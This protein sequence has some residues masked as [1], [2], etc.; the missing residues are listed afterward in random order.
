MDL[1]GLAGLPDQRD[2]D[3]TADGAALTYARRYA[4]FALV[5]IAGED[6][7]DA[8]EMPTDL[9]VA[10]PPECDF[11]ATLKGPSKTTIHKPLLLSTDAS[12]EL[13]DVLISE[14]RGQ[15]DEEQLS[16][17]AQR[18]L[19]AKNTLT[20][21]DARMVEATYRS[22]MDTTFAKNGLAISQ[23]AGRAEAERQN[24]Q[25]TGLGTA[26]GSVISLEKPTRRRSKA[27]LAHVRAQTCVVC[28]RQ[29][30]DA[31]HLKFAQA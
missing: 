3:P 31:H 26:A 28:Q 11:R 20:I 15:A 17:W 25:M 16:S 2:H 19:P 5:G 9:P 29:P 4:L 21:D 8:P 30:C 1:L 27:H 6:D 10:A 24:G 12:A 23:D 13:R 14:L 7:L 18:R 22:M